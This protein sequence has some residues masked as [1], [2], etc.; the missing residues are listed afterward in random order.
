MIAIQVI[1]KSILINARSGACFLFFCF[2]FIERVVDNAHENDFY[3][4]LLM[5]VL[6]YGFFNVLG[7][8]FV[9]HNFV[10]FCLTYLF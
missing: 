1:L 7:Y 9:L 5:S 4:F 6:Y 10:Y 2:I 3:V 8:D